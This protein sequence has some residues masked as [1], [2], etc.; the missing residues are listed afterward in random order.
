MSEVEQL[1][2]E[3]FNNTVNDTYARNIAETLEQYKED[4]KRAFLCGYAKGETDEKFR[5]K[6]VVVDNPKT[7]E[8]LEQAKEIIKKLYED[9]YSIADVED[10]N[11]G[12]WEDD[13]SQAKQ[14]LREI[15]ITNAIQKA[16]EGLNLDKIADEVEQDIKEQNNS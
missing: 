10:T 8:Q 12:L 2:E 9:C 16:N 6:Q 7:K 3:H 4:V 5:T 13:L 14:F 1:A 11:L 15:D